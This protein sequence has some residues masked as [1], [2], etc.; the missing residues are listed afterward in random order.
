M[1]CCTVF[2]WHLVWQVILGLES[3]SK[4]R[5][6]RPLFLQSYSSSQIVVPF[7]LIQDSSYINSTVYVAC[8]TLY[9]REA[10]YSSSTMFCCGA[11][12]LA[13][14]RLILNLQFQTFHLSHTCKHCD[15]E[16][17][18][19][20]RDKEESGHQTDRQAPQASPT[21]CRLV[22]LARS[23]QEIIQK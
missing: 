7:C 12:E 6:H 10:R 5:L 4:Y 1:K 3:T 13:C 18:S 22:V 11:C 2:F 19:L 8:C 9:W 15:N 16:K 20:D 23:C 14:P 21:S 17:L